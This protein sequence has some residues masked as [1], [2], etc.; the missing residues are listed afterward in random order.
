VG[1]VGEHAR[2]AVC[3]K[4]RAQPAVGRWRQ[5]ELCDSTS[6]KIQATR[7]GQ[8]RDPRPTCIRTL[9]TAVLS[10]SKSF[11]GGTKRSSNDDDDGSV[12]ATSKQRREEAP[13]E[14]PQRQPS[15]HDALKRAAAAA[16]ASS[17]A[18]SADELAT[19]AVTAPQMA[20]AKRGSGTQAAVLHRPATSA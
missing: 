1:M 5:N 6:R 19:T 4:W 10:S 3:V 12:A 13:L 9:P 14:R 15:L 16:A 7:M 11:L 8:H 18:A 2:A 20:G 17:A